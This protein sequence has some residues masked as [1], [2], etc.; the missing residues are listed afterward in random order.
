MRE[1]FLVKVDKKEEAEGI[2]KRDEEIS[3]G[4]I[5]VKSA[6]SLDIDEEGYFIILDATEHSIKKAVT[7]LKN[8]AHAYKDKEKVLYAYEKQEETAMQ[9]FGNIMGD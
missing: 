7:M 5:I 8:T 4:S 2:L 9:G 6:S 1:V 3:R